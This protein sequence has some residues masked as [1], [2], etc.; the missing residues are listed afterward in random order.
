MLHDPEALVAAF[1]AFNRWMD[2]DW[3]F[4]YR[5]RIFAAPIFTLVDPEAAVAELEWALSRDA[6]FI[7]MVPGPVMTPAGG[8]SPADPRHDRF[9]Q[10]VNDSGVTLVVHGGD[11]WYS[12]YLKD[13]GDTAE[14]EA[15]R[16]NAFRSLVSHNSV[17]DFF[18]SLI[19]RPTGSR[20][21][22]SCAP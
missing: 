19:K 4:S 21:R 14:R 3:G 6:R 2:D 9:W 1:R 5:E 15:F 11:S 18:A 12:S 13:W 8:H 22:P 10:L 20:N 7:L 17:Q 16:Q